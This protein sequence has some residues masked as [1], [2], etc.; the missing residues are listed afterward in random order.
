MK[1][2]NGTLLLLILTVLGAAL[3]GYLVFRVSSVL[4]PRTAP[5]AAAA[6]TPVPAPTAVATPAP[7]P[8]PT[9]EPTPT[10]VPTP[11]P[12][13]FVSPIDFPT[14]WEKNRDI[15]AWIEVP[16]TWLHYP[17]LQHPTDDVYYL[18][19]TPEGYEG[20]PGSIFTY[21]IE[22]KDFDQ[23]NT[24]IYGHN[25]MDGSM[26]GNLKNY[27]SEDYMRD[28]QILMIYT[29][30]ATLTY[31][32]FAAVTY[33]DR[34]ITDAYNDNDE[35]SCAQYLLSIV[36]IMDGTFVDDGIEE[37]DVSDR[38]VTLST[39]IGGMP[40][41]RLLVVAKLVD[42]DPPQPEEPEET[43]GPQATAVILHP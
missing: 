8:V 11:T 5:T 43:P 31:R 19:R 40:N 37:V 4:L 39:C 30:E 27:R 28:H 38:F 34:L 2:K 42:R 24:V 18:N 1:R 3:F 36:T 21:R 29:P 26:F 6:G 13:P 33:D 17:I 20:Y 15:Y 16:D 14:L 10:P 41:N 32:I 12:T 7:T 25:M 22:G 23:F 9:P 35:R